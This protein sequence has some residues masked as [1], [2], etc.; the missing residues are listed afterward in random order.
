MKIIIITM[1]NVYTI[2]REGVNRY[3]LKSLNTNKV[4]FLTLHNVL[5]GVKFY[6]NNA[7]AKIIFAK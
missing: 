6:R 4:T 3:A 5:Q 2:T 1:F 7:T